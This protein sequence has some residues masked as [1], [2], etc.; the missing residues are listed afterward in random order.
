MITLVITQ[1]NGVRACTGC[2]RVQSATTNTARSPEVLIPLQMPKL[3][4]Q[5]DQVRLEVGPVT[6]H[7]GFK[8]V[9]FHIKPRKLSLKLLDPH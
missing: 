4:R 2:A 9:L 3:Q 1:L 5:L 7:T 6:G 8:A